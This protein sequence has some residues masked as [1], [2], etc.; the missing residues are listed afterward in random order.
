MKM[1]QGKT[2]IH[3]SN[4]GKDLL[5][6]DLRRGMVFE[7][8]SNSTRW[9]IF[10]KLKYWRLK[11]I[12]EDY[13]RSLIINDATLNHDFKCV[14]D[15]PKNI[16]SDKAVR[17]CS[18]SVESLH[19]IRQVLASRLHNFLSIIFPTHI[20][21]I[22]S[23][24]LTV[25]DCFKTHGMDR[26]L[27]IGCSDADYSRIASAFGSLY[28]T[29]SIGVFTEV[30]SDVDSSVVIGSLQ[31]L[32]R[33]IQCGHL[34]FNKGDFDII[35]A[36]DYQSRKLAD[37]KMVFNYFQANIILTLFN[38]PQFHCMPREFKMSASFGEK[39]VSEKMVTRD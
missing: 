38:I 21:K 20:E 6:K 10:T 30:R 24:V 7:Q 36:Y 32:C 29:A 27:I 37:F 35:I 23:T 17:M 4:S 31:T 8:L 33:E 25:R 12:S 22:T 3:K 15:D 5:F 18:D 34:P 19:Y 11:L 16:D 13:T 14:S 28:P 2:V 26:A 39:H 9:I 1:T